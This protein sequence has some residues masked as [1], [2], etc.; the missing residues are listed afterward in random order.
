MRPALRLGL[1]AGFAGFLMAMV[2]GATT[3]LLTFWVVGLVVGVVLGAVY[4]MCIVG[5]ISAVIFGIYGCVHSSDLAGL[6]SRCRT[7]GA[8]VGGVLSLP[9]AISLV[10]SWASLRVLASLWAIAVSVGP[11]VGLGALGG[12]LAFDLGLSGLTRAE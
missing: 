10:L 8:F 4:G 3:G 6:R 2:A 7:A 9:I 12:A 1:S 11:G 5:P